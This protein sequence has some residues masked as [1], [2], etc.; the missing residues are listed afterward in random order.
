MDQAWKNKFIKK[1]LFKKNRLDGLANKEW[2]MTV[3]NV[4]GL[5]GGIL[6]A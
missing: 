3:I 5:C 2:Y 4:M 1:Q 6:E